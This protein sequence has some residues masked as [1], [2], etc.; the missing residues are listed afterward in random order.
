MIIV[1]YCGGLGNQMFQY[2]MQLVLTKMYDNQEIKGEKYHYFLENEHNGFEL[3]NYF[4]IDINMATKKEVRKV[5]N[6]IIPNALYSKL[7]LKIKRG[8]LLKYQ[9]IYLNLMNK[10][11]KNKSMKVINDE[12]HNNYVEKIHDLGNGDWYLRGLWQRVD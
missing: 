4:G 7:P 2:A 1:K 3:T 10:I 12:K 6:G 11:L 5:Y 8:I 9:Y